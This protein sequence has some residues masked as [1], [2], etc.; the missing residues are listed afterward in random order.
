MRAYNRIPEPLLPVYI[1]ETMTY[2]NKFNDET[3]I[4]EQDGKWN[5]ETVNHP[6]LS[7]DERLN[8]KEWYDRRTVY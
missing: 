4:F 3:Y 8:E 2:L 1:D 5:E 6:K 7:L